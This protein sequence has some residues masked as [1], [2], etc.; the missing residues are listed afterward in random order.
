MRVHVLLNRKAGTL[1][2]GAGVDHREGVEALFQQAGIPAV[3][4]VV[5]GDG[6]ARGARRALEA[7]AEVVVAG[8]GDGTL[9]TVAG[10][11]AGTSVPLGVL[12]L[13]TL[14]HFAHD[15]GIPVDLEQA[16]RVIAAAKS[17]SIDVAAV[18]GRVFINN[19]SIG[20][21]PRLVLARDVV[22]DR[23]GFSK[24]TAMAL[25]LLAT[26]RRMPLVRVRLDADGKSMVRKTPLVFI[27]NNIYELDWAS[28][29]TR[30]RLDAGELSLYVANVQT[31]WGALR[32]MWRALLGHLNQERDF[33]RFQLSACRIDA[34]RHRLHV[35]V[36][37]EVIRL[38]PPLEYEIRS[39][40]LEVFVP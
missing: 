18:N 40:Q 31:R 34:R 32:L 10:V 17:V 9:S 33:Q 7:G 30:S 4:Q 11:L 13:G 1:S 35:A 37:G 8:G 23:R 39:R 24:W 5:G 14:N 12:P 16:V 26:C 22:R 3:V 29:G 28:G 6:M 19:S 38:A 36:D 2:S 27:G 20:I 15:L 21:Y 25:A